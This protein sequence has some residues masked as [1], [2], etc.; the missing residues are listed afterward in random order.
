MSDTKRMTKY[1]LEERLLEDV[2]KA[3]YKYD[4]KLSMVAAL[5]ILDLAKDQI[6]EDAD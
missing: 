5:G 4:G 3:I 1:R 2:L 6:K